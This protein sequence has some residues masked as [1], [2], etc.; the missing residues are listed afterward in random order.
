M[1]V[2]CDLPGIPFLDRDAQLFY[3]LQTLP[4]VNGNKFFHSLFIIIG[5]FA[6]NFPVNGDSLCHVFMLLDHRDSVY[7]RFPY[8]DRSGLMDKEYSPLT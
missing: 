5:G 6:Q 8:C 4:E 7:P 3:L 2:Y 1:G